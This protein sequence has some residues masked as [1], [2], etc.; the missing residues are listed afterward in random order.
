MTI[1]DDVADQLE[2]INNLSQLD[3]SRVKF[4]GDKKLKCQFSGNQY[5]A[6]LVCGIPP[7][8]SPLH[9]GFGP[10]NIDATGFSLD[11]EQALASGWLRKRDVLVMNKSKIH[12]GGENTVL[13]D[14]LWSRHHIFVV[15]LPPNTP[16][17]TPVTAVWKE[18]TRE[19]K[20]ISQNPY[21]RHS[22]VRAAETVLDT[23]TSTVI[24]GKSVACR[25]FASSPSSSPSSSKNSR[26]KRGSAA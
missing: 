21:Q 19:M 1:L 26:V 5:Y 16:K 6:T 14:W 18:A 13:E 8:S 7:R 23:F 11:V 22:V 15:Y 17:W 24:A 20:N 25:Q 2:Y 3:P 4:V 12:T 10:G 9:Y